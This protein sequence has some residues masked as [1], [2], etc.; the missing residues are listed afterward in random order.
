[1]VYVS[2]CYTIAEICFKQLLLS[3]VSHVTSKLCVLRGEKKHNQILIIDDGY[4]TY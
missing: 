4:E 3:S 1:M 2:I